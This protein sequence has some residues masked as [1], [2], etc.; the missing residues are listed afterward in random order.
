MNRE[1]LS[2]KYKDW[3]D[4]IITFTRALASSNF[5]WP[6]AKCACHAMCCS[7][8]CCTVVFSRSQLVINLL[9]IKT[10]IISNKLQP[11]FS[12]QFQD[13]QW[14]LLWHVNSITNLVFGRRIV[15]D[16]RGAS[17]MLK[18]ARSELSKQC[19]AQEMI[20]ILLSSLLFCI[21]HPLI[22]DAVSTTNNNFFVTSGIVIGRGQGSS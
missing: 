22:I 19:C 4:P 2:D 14:F 12:C 10:S 1:V 20:L 11:T 8:L 13:D 3:Y 5:S 15:V 7:V 9:A 17:M 21:T 6:E 16:T 18:Y